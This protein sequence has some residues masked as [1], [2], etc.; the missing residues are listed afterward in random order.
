MTTTTDKTTIDR[1][2]I[3]GAEGRWFDR[4]AAVLFKE[5]T[6]FDGN[7]HISRVTGSQWFHQCLYFTAGG[8]WVLHRWSNYQNEPETY[9]LIELSEAIVWLIENRCFPAEVLQLP[10]KIQSEIATILRS[11]EV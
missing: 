2:A 9:Q 6:W 3:T 5:D 10:E 4:V 11:L 7:N 8:S 1:V